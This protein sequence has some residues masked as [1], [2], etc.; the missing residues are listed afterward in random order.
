M[1]SLRA[2]RG[3]EENAKLGHLHRGEPYENSRES[4]VVRLSEE[5]RGLN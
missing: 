1:L 2:P 3:L 5:L 4:I